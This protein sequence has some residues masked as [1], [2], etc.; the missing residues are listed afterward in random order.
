MLVADD[1][2]HLVAHEATEAIAVA[3]YAER[4]GQRDT[5]APA[6]TVAALRGLEE[7]GLP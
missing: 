5:R 3:I 2:I 4:I 7:G 6:A 1:E